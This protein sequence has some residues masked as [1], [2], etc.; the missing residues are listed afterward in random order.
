[1]E[2][3]LDFTKEKP[4]SQFL[5]FN[6]HDLNLNQLLSRKQNAVQDLNLR[7][8]NLKIQHLLLPTTSSLHSLRP[9]LSSHT[10][11]PPPPHTTPLSHD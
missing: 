1:M 8:S 5:D 9:L 6:F 3:R 4:S 7:F 10:P 11:H 2:Q